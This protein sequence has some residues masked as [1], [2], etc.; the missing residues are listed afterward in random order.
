MNVT[1]E[2]RARLRSVR[3]VLSDMD[4]VLYVGNSALPG[5]QEFFDYLDASGRR[6]L[7]VTNNSSRTSQTF[8]EKLAGM[9]VRVSPENILGSAQATAAWLAEH[10]AHGSKVLV[11]GEQSL[12][13]ALAETTSLPSLLKFNSWTATP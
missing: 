3:A 9:N 13:S 4:G 12:R 2:A 11:M 1:E 10:A 7:C 6:W 5:V 8:S